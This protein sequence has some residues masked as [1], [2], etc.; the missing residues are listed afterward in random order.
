MILREESKDLY[1]YRQTGLA[2]AMTTSLGLFILIIGLMNVY[3]SDGS[4]ALPIWGTGFLCWLGWLGTFGRYVCE[5]D[6]K[7][8]EVRLKASCLYSV[9]FRRY[10]LNN[11][12]YFRLTHRKTFSRRYTVYMV[13]N[14]ETYI[15]VCTSSSQGHAVEMCNAISDFLGKPVQIDLL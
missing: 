7:S 4:R 9:F 15:A 2:R 1:I 8:H 5:F 10:K 12:K 13:L 6:L 3:F 14:D 11:V